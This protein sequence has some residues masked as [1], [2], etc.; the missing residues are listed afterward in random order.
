MVVFPYKENLVFDMEIIRKS[1]KRVVKPTPLV[2]IHEYDTEDGFVSGG[3]A[4]IKGRYPEVGYVTNE[5]LKEL[6]YVLSGSGKLIMLNETVEFSEGDVLFI[7]H[8][9]VFA[10][11]GDMVLFMATTPKFDPAQHKEVDA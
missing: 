2:E 8:K 4:I 5:V 1:E 6:V 9:E 10:W 11:E 7:D 3:T